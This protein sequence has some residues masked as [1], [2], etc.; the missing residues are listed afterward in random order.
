MPVYD[1]VIIGSGLGGLECAYILAK[2]GQRVCVLEKNRQ[3]G[4]TLQ[5][6]SRDKVIFDTGIHYIGGLDKGQNLNQFFTYFNLMDKLRLKRM[7]ENGFDRISFE[8]DPQDYPHAMGYEPF[9]ESLRRLFPAEKE[10]LEK[11]C[12]ELQATCKA[13]PMYNL[14]PNKDNEIDFKY[15][16]VNTKDFIADCVKDPKLQQILAGS[17]PL[18]AGC[19][20]KTPLYVHALVCNTYIESAWKCIDGGAQIARILCKNI[21]DLGGEIF[22]YSEVTG[23]TYTNKKIK[24]AIL[25]NGEQVEGKNFI[26]NIHP[27]RTVEMIEEGYIRKLYR[28][29]IQRLENSISVFTLHIVFK[30]KTFPYLNYNYYHYTKQDVWNSIYYKEENWPEGYA[31][32]V[33]YSSKCPEGYADSM[34]IMAYMRYEEVKQWENTFHTIPKNRSDRGQSYLDFKEEKSQKL[35][36]LLEKKF[37]NI[38]SKI[39][40][41]YSSTPLSFRDYI[42]TSD[43]SLYGITKDWR[44]PMQTFISPRTKISNL[45]LTGQNLNM[46]GVLGVTVGSVVTCGQFVGA[47]YLIDKI[48]TAT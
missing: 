22:N 28:K 13:F 8:D 31:L 37:P 17:N 47:E 24:T 11:Y 40:S 38:R 41:Y 12:S 18:Y 46:H 10:G 44:N 6:F 2:E 45:F 29:R 21:K 23:F 27:A 32:F 34:N 36:S 4:G 19:P 1:T 43:G 26:S 3:L 25:K 42:G 5:I 7:D 35:L 30:E 16:K 33:P 15:L 20:D 9:K 48:R 39:K 14:Y